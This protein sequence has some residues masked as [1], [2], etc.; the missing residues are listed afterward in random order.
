MSKTTDIA[1]IAVLGLMG[2]LIYKF[3]GTD[4]FKGITQ[5]FETG[6]AAGAIGGGITELI[7][8]SDETIREERDR[9]ISEGTAGLMIEQETGIPIDMQTPEQQYYKAGE[10]V[11]AETTKTLGIPYSLIPPL[12]AFTIGSGIATGQIRTEYLETLPLEAQEVAILKEQEQ[13]RD[14]LETPE[15]QTLNLLGLGLPSVLTE[16]IWTTQPKTLEG[17]LQYITM[18]YPQW[19]TRARLTGG[20][21]PS[22]SS[23]LDTV[24]RAAAKQGYQY[25]QIPIGESRP[26]PYVEYAKTQFKDI[27]LPTIPDPVLRGLKLNE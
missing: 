26:D 10:I 21:I 3:I 11:A 9:L 15:G 16:T 5:G 12:S 19:A 13:R 4:I 8:P 7:R 25:D 23:M 18:N 2:Y 27:I 20:S 14:Y 22:L 17:T 24:R 1:T 6:G